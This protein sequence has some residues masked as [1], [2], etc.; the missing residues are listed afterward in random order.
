MSEWKHTDACNERTR[1]INEKNQKYA[2]TY[3]NYCKVCSGCGGS[4]YSYDPSP[5]GVSLGSGSMEDFE[6]CEHCVMQ[7][8]CPRCGSLIWD[9][10]EEG[11]FVCPV[12]GLNDESPDGLIPDED[13]GCYEIY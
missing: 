13:C 3:P 10:S 8:N 2:E 1:K 6:P 11:F 9:M 4:S 12:C 7:G 5:S